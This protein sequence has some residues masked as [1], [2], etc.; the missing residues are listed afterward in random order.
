VRLEQ[1]IDWGFFD[2]PPPCVSEIARAGLEDRQ[3]YSDTA[4]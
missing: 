4:S 3:I 2:I 1:K